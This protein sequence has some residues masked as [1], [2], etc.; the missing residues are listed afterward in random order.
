MENMFWIGCHPGLTNE[1]LHYVFEAFDE[2]FKG[3]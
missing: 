1:M 2:Y 3:K